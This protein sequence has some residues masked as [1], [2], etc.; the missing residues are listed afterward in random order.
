MH[1]KV[2]WW[3][4]AIKGFAKQGLHEALWFQKSREFAIGQ[5]TNGGVVFLENNVVVVPMSGSSLRGGKRRVRRVKLLNTGN[6][7]E[8]MKLVGKLPLGIRNLKRA[9]EKLSIEAV[10]CLCTHPGVIKF[11][12]INDTT[13]ECYG[14]W[15]NRRMLK[16][17]FEVDIK[18][19]DPDDIGD[20][21]YDANPYTLS[22]GV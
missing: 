4:D 18:Y 13:M 16:N 7:P 20:T 12:A 22:Y 21:R 2:F 8:N 17:M 11:F 14:Q 1:L 19:C 5:G 15:W 3:H 9:R 10:V 6:I